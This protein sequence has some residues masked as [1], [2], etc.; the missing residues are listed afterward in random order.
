[1]HDLNEIEK[2]FWFHFALWCGLIISTNKPNVYSAACFV[3]VKKMSWCQ[4]SR[5]HMDRQMFEPLWDQS[6]SLS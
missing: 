2:F 1:M 3:D 5:A 6:F 4:K